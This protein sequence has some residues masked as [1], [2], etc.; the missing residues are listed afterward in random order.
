MYDSIAQQLLPIETAI[1][2]ALNMVPSASKALDMLI[3]SLEPSGARIAYRFGSRLRAGE[4][5]GD[6]DLYDLESLLQPVL[7]EIEAGWVSEVIADEHCPGGA[8][9]NKR[10]TNRAA[11]LNRTVEPLVALQRCLQLIQNLR[12]ADRITRRVIAETQT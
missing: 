4:M 11:E 5:F 8:W 1:L 7:A 2:E 9:I 6:R 3:D 12:R 10:L